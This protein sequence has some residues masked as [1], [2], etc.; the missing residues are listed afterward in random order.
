VG[1]FWHM[2]SSEKPYYLRPDH[3]TTTGWMFPIDGSRHHAI[4]RLLL[5]LDDVWYEERMEKLVEHDRDTRV[6]R[7]FCVDWPPLGPLSERTIHLN[8]VLK[9]VLGWRVYEEYF[10]S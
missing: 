7:N 6:L 5:L 10:I 4:G 1:P 3:R 2:K 8:E 9:G